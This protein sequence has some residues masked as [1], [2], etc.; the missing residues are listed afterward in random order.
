MDITLSADLLGEETEGDLVE[1]LATDG[2]TVTQGQTVAQI[3]TSKVV[4]DVESPA[5]GTLRHRAEEGDVVEL[6]QVIAVVEE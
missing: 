6:G 2:D 1:W 5:A 3:E 4:V